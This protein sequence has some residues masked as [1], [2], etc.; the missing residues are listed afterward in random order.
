MHTHDASLRQKIVHQG[1]DT[2]LGF[3]GVGCASNQNQLLTK[4]HQDESRRT[5]AIALRVCLETGEVNYGE[6][7]LPGTILL[8]IA[9]KHRP[10]KERMPGQFSDHSDRDSI[11][12]VGSSTGILL[13]QV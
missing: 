4:I 1:E 6:F 11:I 12:P 9:D 8:L 7:R 3:T 10:S 5:R 13:R 2:L